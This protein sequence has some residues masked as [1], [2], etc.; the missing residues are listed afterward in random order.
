MK[1]AMVAMFLLVGVF[2]CDG[3]SEPLGPVKQALRTEATLKTSRVPKR[4]ICALPGQIA[5][6]EICNGFDDDCDGVVD[7]G[8]CNDPCDA[9]W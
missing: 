3:L 4:P 6:A 9:P 5:V 7:E 2:G 8:V 1:T